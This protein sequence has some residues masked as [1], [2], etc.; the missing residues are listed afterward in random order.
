MEPDFYCSEVKRKEQVGTCEALVFHHKG[1]Q[2]LGLVPREVWEAPNLEMLKTQLVKVLNQDP[3]LA[4][5]G[6]GWGLD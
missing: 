4:E 2:T 3:V 6:L 5:P 1:G